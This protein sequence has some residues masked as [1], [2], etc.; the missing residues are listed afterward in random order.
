MLVRWRK[1]GVRL[2]IVVRSIRKILYRKARG[3]RRSGRCS[4]VR[5]LFLAYIIVNG[6][7][8][9]NEIFF[10]V[11]VVVLVKRDVG[12]ILLVGRY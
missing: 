12:R 5:K 7:E 6:S 9:S 4:K 2:S 11:S 3:W 10:R 1:F 8:K